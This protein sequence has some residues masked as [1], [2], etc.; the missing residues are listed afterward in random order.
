METLDKLINKFNETGYNELAEVIEDSLDDMFN[1]VEVGNTFHIIHLDS[2]YI[3]GIIGTLAALHLITDEECMG[4]LD[5]IF[6]YLIEKKQM[7]SG[8]ADVEESEDE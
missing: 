5:E 7:E 8:Y 6:S 2:M 3:Q 1:D 4:A